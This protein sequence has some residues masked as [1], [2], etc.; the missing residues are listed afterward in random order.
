M[1]LIGVIDILIWLDYI[2]LIKEGDFFEI[3][4]CIVKYYY[5]LKISIIIEIIIKLVE[6]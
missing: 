6:K 5:G 1:D 2:F 3:F 4:N